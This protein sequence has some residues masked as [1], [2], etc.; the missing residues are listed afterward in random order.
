MSITLLSITGVDMKLPP[1]FL[2][3]NA[4]PD[5]RSSVGALREMT[6][7]TV[8]GLETGLLDLDGRI[9]RS[10]RAQPANL[11]KNISLWRWR[12]EWPNGMEEDVIQQAVQSGAIPK[13]GREYYG[14][15]FYLK[16]TIT[17]I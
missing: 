16:E 8:T 12:P 2:L 6:V 11:W 15:L 17:D 3:P 14:T 9:P 1:A 7:T 5:L 4:D 13:G 10:S